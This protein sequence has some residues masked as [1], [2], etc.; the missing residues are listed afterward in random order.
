MLDAK[1]L[2][3]HAKMTRRDHIAATA[4]DLVGEFLYYGR[5]ED[6]DLPRGAIQEAIAAGEVTVDEIADLFR[7][8]LVEGLAQ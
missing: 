8:E 7:R 6:E 1:N 2:P 4:S 5:K 3:P